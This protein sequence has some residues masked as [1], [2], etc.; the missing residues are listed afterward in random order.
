MNK[1]HINGIQLNR[2]QRSTLAFL[3][4]TEKYINQICKPSYI[5]DNKS[6]I[7]PTSTISSRLMFSSS[8]VQSP[9]NSLTDTYHTQNS[10]FFSISPKTERISNPKFHNETLIK[11]R[12]KIFT[13]KFNKNTKTKKPQKFRKYHRLDDQEKGVQ[14]ESKFLLESI[15]ASLHHYNHFYNEKPRF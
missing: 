7:S 14:S 11:L 1:N 6:I 15:P 9:L 12:K 3:K 8:H 10:K 13:K 4:E 2:N 5:Y